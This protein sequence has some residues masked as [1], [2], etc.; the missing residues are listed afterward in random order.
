M[1]SSTSKNL[2]PEEEQDDNDPNSKYN[3]L[4]HVEPFHRQRRID[5][6]LPFN[7]Q[8]INMEHIVFTNSIDGRYTFDNTTDLNQGG[9]WKEIIHNGIGQKP[10]T[11]TSV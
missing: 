2:T 5:G 4:G 10:T 9:I 6:S 3:R 7:E 11:A 8:I 1:Q